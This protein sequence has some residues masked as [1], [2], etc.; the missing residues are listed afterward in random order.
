MKR[1]FVMG[2]LFLFHTAAS[3]YIERASLPKLLRRL[4]EILRTGSRKYIILLT[5]DDPMDKS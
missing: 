2:N 4:S 5:M 1:L 3:L